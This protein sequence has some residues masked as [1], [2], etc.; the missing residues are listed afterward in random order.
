MDKVFDDGVLVITGRNSVQI[1]RQCTL[2]LGA[3]LGGKDV[4]AR[5]KWSIPHQPRDAEA[6]ITAKGKL[7]VTK[8]EPG[9]TQV[10]VHLVYK[11]VTRTA[12]IQVETVEDRPG[13][14]MRD[15]G[16]VFTA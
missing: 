16:T 2:Q 14:R 11:D 6:K 8:E 9:R 3:L 12:T 7:T 1:Q 10:P 13:L 15:D 4:T 5:A